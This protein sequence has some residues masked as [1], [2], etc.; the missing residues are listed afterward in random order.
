MLTTGT[1]QFRDILRVQHLHQIDQLQI[2]YLELIYYKR[3]ASPWKNSIFGAFSS[4]D[5]PAGFAGYIPSSRWFK[6]TFD[7][8][9]ESHHPQIDQYMAMLPARICAIDHSHKIT[10]H[11]ILADGVSI[12]V[13]LL[14]VTNELGQ[15]QVLALVATKAHAQ[16]EYALKQMLESLKMYGNDE[17]WILYTDNISDKAFLEKYFPSLKPGITPIDKFSELPEFQIPAHDQIFNKSSVSQIETALA[18]FQELLI[19]FPESENITIGFD[20]EW[21]VNI[22]PGKSRQGKTAVAT[23]AHDN[24]IYLLQIAWLHGNKFPRA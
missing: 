11:I 12:F 14:T 19:E 24:T 13:G 8:F 4:F 22:T 18:T 16:F 9:V 2:Q 23:I 20:L 7:M 17:P 5:D 1:Q 21:N 10:K 6:D 15:I 3:A